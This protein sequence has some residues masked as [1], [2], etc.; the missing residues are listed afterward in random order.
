MGEHGGREIGGL[1]SLITLR[2]GTSSK[3]IRRGVTWTACGTE[4]N[5]WRKQA[6][7]GGGV[8]AGAG[9]AATVGERGVATLRSLMATLGRP[10][11]RTGPWVVGGGLR[12]HHD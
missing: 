7:H 8:Q 10:G 9:V 11:A 2:S 4:G 5:V 12:L 3:V 1:G 6:G